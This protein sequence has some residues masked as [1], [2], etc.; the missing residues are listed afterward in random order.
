MARKEEEAEG[1]MEALKK[2]IDEVHSRLAMV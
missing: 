1:A 2:E